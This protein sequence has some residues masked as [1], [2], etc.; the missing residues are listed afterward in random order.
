MGIDEHVQ[1]Y[2]RELEV[3]HK[4]KRRQII[5]EEEPTIEQFEL[6][7]SLDNLVTVCTSCHRKLESN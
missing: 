5:D 2:N 6:A 4:V 7:N 1:E 3:H